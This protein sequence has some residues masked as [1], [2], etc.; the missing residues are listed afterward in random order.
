VKLVKH[1]CNLDLP[2]YFF[3]ERVID[4][5]N[6]LSED[7]ISCETVNKFKGKV[8]MMRRHKMG[9]FEDHT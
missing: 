9:F 8:D 7:C 2:K 1:R 5:W 4:R 6:Q 3:S